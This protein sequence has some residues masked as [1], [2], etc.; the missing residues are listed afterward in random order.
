MG[1]VNNLELEAILQ[2][3]P[4]HFFFVVHLDQLQQLSFYL[5][6]SNQLFSGFSVFLVAKEKEKKSINKKEVLSLCIVEIPR[7][8]NDYSVHPDIYADKTTTTTT[9]SIF[10]LFLTYQCIIVHHV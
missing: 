7:K 2:Y 4:S 1:V 10:S 5:A 3:R 6:L 9:T 8:N